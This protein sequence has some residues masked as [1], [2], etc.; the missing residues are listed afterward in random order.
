MELKIEMMM[1]VGM[2]VLCALVSFVFF[3]FKRKTPVKRAGVGF[4]IVKIV[5]AVIVIIMIV[6]LMK[7]LSGYFG[8]V[9]SLE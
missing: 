2:S 6:V 7:N 5:L 1:A 9:E 3:V 8:E 4:P